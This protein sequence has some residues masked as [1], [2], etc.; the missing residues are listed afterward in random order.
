MADDI[1]EKRTALDQTFK[2]ALTQ[3]REF[4]GEVKANATAL[5]DAERENA[6]LRQQLRKLQSRAGDVDQLRKQ[7]QSLQ[8][9]LQNARATRP[10]DASDGEK[11]SVPATQVNV[12]TPPASDEIIPH[13]TYLLQ[14][15]HQQAAAIDMLTGLLRAEK[16]RSRKWRMKY[17]IASSPAPTSPEHTAVQG[18]TRPHSPPRLVLQHPSTAFDPMPVDDECTRVSASPE[19][20]E[21]MKSKPTYVKVESLQQT[22]GNA[23]KRR[24]MSSS[25][26]AEAISSIAEDGEDHNRKWSSN[27]AR[28]LNPKKSSP[29]LATAHRRLRTLLAEPTT[30]PRLFGPDAFLK[31]GWTAVDPGPARKPQRFLLPKKIKSR[32]DEED[33][34][35]FR[36][37]PL[38]RLSLNDFKINPATNEGLD[39]AYQ[40][41][42]RNHHDRKCLSGCT[43]KCCFDKWKALAHTLYDTDNRGDETLDQQI[44]NNSLLLD[45]L[46]HGSEEKIRTLTPVARANLI[47][48]ARVRELSARHSKHRAAHPRAQSPVGFWETDMPGTQETEENR[49]MAEKL[50]REEVE[51]RHSDAMRGGARWMFA[52]E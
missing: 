12:D 26:G 3:W 27:A 28:T 29:A 49:A 25:R 46:G 50:E 24:K 9:Q 33:E 7:S 48:E 35:P 43:D 41:V 21:Q 34:S 52:D 10:Q 42:V 11:F 45:M 30:R 14:E 51:R 47:E 39:Y 1:E 2:S 16:D 31:P 23:R 5:Q 15:N 17:D 44:S 36:S 32:A 38:D 22:S 18:P 20:V 4:T 37:R 13:Y 6:D 40:D 8:R 19:P